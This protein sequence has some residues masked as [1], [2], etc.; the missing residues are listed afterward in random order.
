MTDRNLWGTFTIAEK[1]S[2]KSIL[3]EQADFLKESTNNILM[4][5]IYERPFLEI[6][7]DFVAKYAPITK[8][9]N[10]IKCTFNVVVPKMNNYKMALFDVVYSIL[11]FYPLT[12]RDAINKQELD[13]NNQ[14]EFIYNLANVI[15]SE[16]TRKV[17]ENLILQSR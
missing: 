11:D 2:P 7:S 12:I 13:C 4:G 1:K 17:I 6:D 16:Y 5:E 9:P 14:D 10:I 8:V 3:Q 15:Q